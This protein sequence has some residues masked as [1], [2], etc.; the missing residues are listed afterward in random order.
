VTTKLELSL[1]ACCTTE[2][3]R[4]APLV[5]VTRTATEARSNYPFFAN[6]LQGTRAVKGNILPCSYFFYLYLTIHLIKKLKFIIDFTMIYFINKK[7][8]HNL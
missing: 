5:V 7:F 3:A 6:I 8:K 4:S 2:S 1:L